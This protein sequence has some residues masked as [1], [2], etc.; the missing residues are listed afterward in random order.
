MNSEYVIVNSEKKKVS[1]NELNYLLPQLIVPGKS[2][3]PFVAGRSGYRF[4]QFQA[5]YC[6]G[7]GPFFE[8]RQS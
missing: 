6:D 4:A 8:R 7:I 5:L 2:A 3:T 1:S